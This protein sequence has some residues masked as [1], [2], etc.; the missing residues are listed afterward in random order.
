MA[1]YSI[2]LIYCKEDVQQI[3]G[4]SACSTWTDPLLNT[5]IPDADGVS[6]ES[7]KSCRDLAEH[8]YSRWL[9]D[10]ND[11]PLVHSWGWKI[12]FDTEPHVIEASAL[13]QHFNPDP[14][15]WHMQWKEDRSNFDV[16]PICVDGNLH[17]HIE[18]ILHTDRKTFMQGRE[19]I[20]SSLEPFVPIKA[21]NADEASKI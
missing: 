13:L 20:C 8:N 21:V 4:M 14:D 11:K 16:P 1:P 7:W 18:N 5:I 6:W 17:R 2:S 9:D 19:H 15:C 10:S 12:S 3:A